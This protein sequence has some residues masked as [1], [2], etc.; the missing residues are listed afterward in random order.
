MIT[1]F[2]VLQF[3]GLVFGALIG[4]KLGSGFYGVPG[5]VAGTVLF[6]F[7]GYQA[8]NLPWRLVLLFEKKRFSKQSTQELIEGLRGRYLFCPNLVLVELRTRGED[9]RPFIPYLCE[10]MTSDDIGTRSRGWVALKS[11]VPEYAALIPAYHPALGKDECI[12][13]AETLKPRGSEERPASRT[14]S[15]T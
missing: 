15:E 8:G 13:I 10:L 4:W 3:A 11:A 7:V 1:I 2:H 6:A 12:R 5:A 14:G 9:V